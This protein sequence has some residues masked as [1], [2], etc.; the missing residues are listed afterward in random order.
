M[1]TRA[2]AAAAVAEGDESEVNCG[3]KNMSARDHASPNRGMHPE[4]PEEEI[5]VRSKEE[6]P[7]T[8]NITMDTNDEPPLAKA[9][10]NVY[11]DNEFAK[12]ILN[13]L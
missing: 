1:T 9:I 7:Q 6:A 8:P 13:A 4:R 3:V 11:E 10:S 5:K 2:Q 12:E